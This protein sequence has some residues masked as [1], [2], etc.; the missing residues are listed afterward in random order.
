MKRLTGALLLV[1]LLLSLCAA[2]GPKSPPQTD[3]TRNL[4]AQ[5]KAAFQANKILKALDVLRDVA[6]EAEKQTPKLLSP[7]SALKVIAYHKQVASLMGAIPD[8]WKGIALAGLDTLKQNLSPA[9]WNQ[10]QPFIELVRGLIDSFVP[11][12]DPPLLPSD[13]F[14]TLY[15]DDLL[16]AGAV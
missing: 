13:L 10:V 14:P 15:L 2:C 12:A 11:G 3:P 5:G 8:G 7:S 16:L 4:S 6:V 1:T 9:E